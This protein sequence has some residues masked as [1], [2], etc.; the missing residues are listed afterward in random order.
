MRTHRQRQKRARRLLFEPLE[1]R[2]LLAP[3]A[4]NDDYPATE[5]N[6]FVVGVPGVLGNDARYHPVWLLGA[7]RRAA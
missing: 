6:F 4:A 7:R 1:Q 2:H 5:D 3:I